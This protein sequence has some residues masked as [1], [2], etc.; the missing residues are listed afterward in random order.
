M[1]RRFIGLFM[2]VLIPLVLMLSYAH[3]EEISDIKISS[4]VINALTSNGSA[5]VIIELKRPEILKKGWKDV[6][7]SNKMGELQSEIATLQDEV[8]F[9]MGEN[10]KLKYKYETVSAIAGTINKNAL[11]ILK[12]NPNVV[13]INIDGEV[14]AT[15][16]QSRPLIK[17]DDVHTLGY[18]G[19]N[20]VVGVLDTGID[21]D[22]PDL[23]DHIVG[24]KC[25]GSCPGGS[26]SAEDDNGHGT[27]VAGIITS[28]GTVAPKGIAPNAKIV[29]VKVLNSA[30]SGSFSDIIAGLDWI[31]R[32]RPDVRVINMSLGGGL[33][34]SACDSA[35]TSLRDVINALNAKAVVIFASSGN[36]GSSTKIGIPA[37]MTNA[38]AVGAVYDSNVG[39]YTSGTAGCTDN[40]TWADKVTCY[41]NSNSLV[42]LLAPGT[43]ITAPGMGGGT[44]TYSGTS[45][46]SPHAAAVAAL[47]LQK[48][49]ILPPSTIISKM[50]ST[51]KW[52]KDTKNNKWFRRVNALNSI[53]SVSIG[54]TFRSIN[55]D[56]CRVVHHTLGSSAT[57][58]YLDKFKMWIWTT[59][60]E[61]EK[62]FIKAA[63]S[64]HWLG[65][66]INRVYSSGAFNILYFRIWKN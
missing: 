31:N 11:S 16:N 37:C 62:L 10:F 1:N 24:Q 43:W 25:F 28:K 63:E 64:N 40:T 49:G 34:S 26:N 15:L 5:D 59:D 29:A 4:E 19:S 50:K 61:A 44:S 54:P 32:Y 8:I 38:H 48:N 58:C 35:L 33:Y 13:S 45:Q 57:W 56:H 17:A 36:N 21:T 53:N 6:I 47:L 23:K 18:T 42:D 55:W 66:Y 14:H 12:A 7:T 27:N 3:S 60:D 51:G 46:A 20:V 65:F 52:I 9:A 22:H 2:M 41:S 30:G 39:K